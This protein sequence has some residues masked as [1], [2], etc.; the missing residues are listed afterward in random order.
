MAKTPSLLIRASSL[1]RLEYE[2][3]ESTIRVDFSSRLEY[4]FFSLLLLFCFPFASSY[5]PPERLERENQH[6]CIKIRTSSI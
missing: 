6:T 1:L 3:H 2:V 5:L 4:D